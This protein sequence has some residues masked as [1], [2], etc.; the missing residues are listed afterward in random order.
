MNLRSEDNQRVVLNKL[1]IGIRVPLVEHSGYVLQND[2]SGIRT[3]V[4]LI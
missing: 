3:T 2:G 4:Y 1:P